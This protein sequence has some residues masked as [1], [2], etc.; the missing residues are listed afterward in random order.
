MRPL[1]Q[2]KLEMSEADFRAITDIAYKEAGL[3]F[4]PEKAS[5]VCSRINRRLRKL[6]LNSFAEYTAF[7][8]SDQGRD[9]RRAMISSLTTNIS[10]FFRE[11]H[12]FDILRKEALPALLDRARAGGRVRLWS[13]GCSTGQEAYSMA[14][15]LLDA[16]PDAASLDIKIL[17]TDID[18]Y[19]IAMAKQGFYDS[20]AV[21]G[22]SSTLMEKFLSPAKNGPRDGYLISTEIQNLISFRELNLLRPW[23]ISRSFDVIFCRNVVIYFDEKTQLSLWPRF[24]SVT[25]P[26]GWLFVGHSERLSDK[27][28]TG[29]ETVGPTTYRRGDPAITN[30][31]VE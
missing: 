20:R 18:P 21:G 3:V 22:I 19:V 17:A 15:T 12:H 11:S 29:F 28:E 30:E 23:P 5:L 4:L 6:R 13:A 9:E 14:M 16:A 25:A 8:T 10:N 7:V 24:E 31:S 26:E 27:L 2:S 1:S